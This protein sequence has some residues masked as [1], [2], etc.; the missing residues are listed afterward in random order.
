MQ[1]LCGYPVFSTFVLLHNLVP[2]CRRCRLFL[3]TQCTFRDEV[4]QYG[5]RLTL[6]VSLDLRLKRSQCVP[7]TIH[8]FIIREF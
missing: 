5:H 2:Y 7:R 6:A 3:V 4:V 8:V 1:T